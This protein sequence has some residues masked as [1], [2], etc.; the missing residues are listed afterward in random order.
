M[1]QISN[2]L[3]G[4]SNKAADAGSK[5]NMQD[6]ENTS[7]LS[8]F[9]QA[10]ESELVS[11]ESGKTLQSSYG[12]EAQSVNVTIDGEVSGDENAD[13]EMIFA[14]L[15]MADVLN[16]SHSVDGKELP[17]EEQSEGY[18]DVTVSLAFEDNTSDSDIVD[19][20]EHTST[21][22]ETLATLSP[23]ELSKIMAFS[24][25]SLKELQALDS[26]AFSELMGEFNL[27]QLAAGEPSIVITSDNADDNLGII[28]NVNIKDNA[29]D[30]A[31]SSGQIAVADGKSE[32]D[33]SV[34]A[35]VA[36]PRT[37]T[38][39]EANSVNVKS[40]MTRPIGSAE[41]S[42]DP[43][44]ILGDKTRVDGNI[45]LNANEPKDPKVLAKADFAVVLDTIATKR[46]S[47]DT[48]ASVNQAS[49]GLDAMAGVGDT[50][51]RS[52]QNQS[53][54][55]PAHKSEVPQFQLSLRPQ[56]EAGG[57]MQEMIQRFS[58]VM[59]Q[60]LITMV[61]NG[62]QQAEIRLDPPELG[63]LTVKIQIQGDQTQVQF[64]V[65]QSQTRDIVE[66]AMP[67]LR[68]MLSQ[69]GLQLTDSHVSQGG[70]GRDQQQEQSSGQGSGDSQLDEIS[71][72][73]ASLVTNPSSSL[74]SAI[75]YYA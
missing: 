48:T 66:Q 55:T 12:I 46:T 34:V 17:L 28:D 54:L 69:E 24:D 65:A 62:I 56:G 21:V 73:E 35:S 6:V 44:T 1:Q 14:Q 67:R 36:I 30:R 47:S 74:H 49:M 61:S 41:A 58:P 72:Q 13:A 26:Q 8:A 20:S 52:L 71:A 25:L 63:H 50:D 59:K 18:F 57:Q 68:D 32:T 22:S 4:S 39:T 11:K 40:D 5:G 3:L 51:S 23:E 64:H 42:V 38:V 2:I 75:D 16:K 70:D 15:N 43:K 7:F 45:Q 19:A 53:S 29:N 9:N 31:Q 37:E 33:K 27:H 10:S 60:Q